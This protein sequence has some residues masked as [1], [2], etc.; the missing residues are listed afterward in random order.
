L[1]VFNG[2]DANTRSSSGLTPLLMVWSGQCVTGCSDE[3]LVAALYMLIRAGGDINAPD[4]EGRTP[5]LYAYVY[6][7]TRQW[8][9]A[10]RLAEADLQRFLAIEGESFAA[11]T[12]VEERHQSRAALIPPRGRAFSE[13]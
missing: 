12:A 9:D 7:K 2:T 11:T 6:N 1:L 13:E 5:N 3:E 8:V 4:K 10:L